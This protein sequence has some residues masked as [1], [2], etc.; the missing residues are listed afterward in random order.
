MVSFTFDDA[1][2][3]AARVDAHMLEQ[4]GARGTF[5]IAGGLVDAW[6]GNWTGTSAS[7]DDIVDFTAG[8]MKSPA[9]PSRTRARRTCYRRGLC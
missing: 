6:S 5:Y 9:T 2:V 1:P 4:Y 3:G 7:A 8:V